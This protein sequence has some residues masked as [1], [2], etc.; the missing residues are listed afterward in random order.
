MDTDHIAID[1]SALDLA[2]NELEA[3]TSV[4]DSMSDDARK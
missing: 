3:A 2:S 4:T 1:C